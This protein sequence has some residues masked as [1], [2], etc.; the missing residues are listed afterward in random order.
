M[1]HRRHRIHFPD[2]TYAIYPDQPANGLWRIGTE[3]YVRSDDW[4]DAI[5]LVRAQQ[6]KLKRAAA[7]VASL[8]RV[9]LDSIHDKAERAARALEKQKRQAQYE[10]TDKQFEIWWERD[11]R[12]RRAEL[13]AEAHI[14]LLAA[15]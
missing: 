10:W 7:L 2:G 9:R 4:R 6:D 8:K 13:I 11:D 3:T 15:Q 1:K 14:I 12:C 5:Q